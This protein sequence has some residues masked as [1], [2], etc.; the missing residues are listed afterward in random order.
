[1]IK[2]LIGKVTEKIIKTM[3]VEK[4][5]GEYYVKVESPEEFRKTVKKAVRIEMAE[6][7]KQNMELKKKIKELENTISVLQ[8]KK[9]QDIMAKISEQKRI[10]SEI[11]KSGQFV[12]PFSF[13]NP[14]EFLDNE[15][16]P[17]ID[18]NGVPNP[19]LQGIRL[20]QLP[21]TVKIEFV[22]SKKKRAKKKEDVT[23]LSPYPPVTISNIRYIFQDITTLI[24]SLRKGILVTNIS[25]EGYLLTGTLPVYLSKPQ[26]KK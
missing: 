7:L 21:E 6:L 4:I 23:F 12:L 5:K 19:Y 18:E 20:V 26:V 16:N 25:P 11:V 24:R 13:N 17:F 3:K 1:M 8:K 22:L 9:E 2:K 10:I 15:G 14:I